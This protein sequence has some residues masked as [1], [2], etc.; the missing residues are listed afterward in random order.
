MAPDEGFRAVSGELSGQAC[1]PAC[2][3]G[4]LAINVVGGVKKLRFLGIFDFSQP[5]F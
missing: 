5:I 4:L 1:S 2:Y 3:Y